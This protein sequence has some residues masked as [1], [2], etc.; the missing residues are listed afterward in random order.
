MLRGKERE[1]EREGG[2]ERGGEEGRERERKRE[3]EEAVNL[4]ATF[5]YQRPVRANV[6]HIRPCMR[7][8]CTLYTLY[9]TE[10][11]Y[12]CVCVDFYVRLSV[13]VY[14]IG[15]FIKG[16]EGEG[17]GGG[18]GGCIERERGAEGL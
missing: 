2:R 3:R 8:G 15:V 5:E 9:S 7:K 4:L 6:F 16:T 12:V 1:R 18:G 13:A 14:F 10:H 11:L 17:G